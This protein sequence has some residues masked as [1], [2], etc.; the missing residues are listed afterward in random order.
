MIK[1]KKKKEW[2][3]P[4]VNYGLLLV[5]GFIFVYPVIHV[6]AGSFSNP[7]RLMQHQG[8]LLWPLGFSLKGYQVV[9]SNPNII[10]GYS[11]TIINMVMGTSV[12]I[13]STIIG[14]Y[15][16]SR[17][18]FMF[19]RFF[20]W[21]IVITMYIGGGMIPNFL[22][23]KNM[24]MLDT[25]WAVIIPGCISTW[26]LIVM[27]TC[28]NQLPASLEESARIDGANDL[29]ILFRIL[30]PLA[31]PTVMVLVLFYAVG[32]WNSWFTPMLYLQNRELYPV[33]LITREI[34][35]SNS[36]GGG[37]SMSGVFSSAAAA[38]IQNLSE[39]IKYSSIVVTALPIICV[40]PFIQKYFV[41]GM[42]LGS[43]KE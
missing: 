29:T 24:G 2:L 3:F 33:A 40:Y 8:G 31:K 35:I 15:V 11:N 23:V 17:K 39:L 14:A 19:R 1:R 32:Q 38:D 36:G 22:L 20:T 4:F 16:L 12:S 34:L 25:R 41:T 30:V 9:L 43:I 6:I 21:M 7:A 42:M 28:F 18:D 37:G 10:S 13:L 27:K 5:L 26:N